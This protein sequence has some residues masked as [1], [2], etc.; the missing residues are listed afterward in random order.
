VL[1]QITQGYRSHFS[2][3]GL[4]CSVCWKCGLQL[5]S[6][7]GCHMGKGHFMSQHNWWLCFQVPIFSTQYGNTESSGLTYQFCNC[8]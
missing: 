1:L 5:G 6:W 4:Y 8:I 3:T 7:C 2:T